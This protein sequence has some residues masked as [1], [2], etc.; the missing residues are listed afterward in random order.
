MRRRRF[1]LRNKYEKNPENYLRDDMLHKYLGFD[2]V[3]WRMLPLRGRELR[4]LMSNYDEEEQ[5]D[6][7]HGVGRL[8]QFHANGGF[9]ESQA[10]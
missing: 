6:N 2:I 9:A 7:S 3:I 1:F 4:A 8:Y 10:P 5:F